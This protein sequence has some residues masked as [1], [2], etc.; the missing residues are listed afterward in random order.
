MCDVATL[1]LDPSDWSLK[2]SHWNADA[3]QRDEPPEWQPTDA[4]A[5]AIR[6]EAS[7]TRWPTQ[8][9]FSA[10]EL[11]PR[12]KRKPIP[13]HEGPETHIFCFFNEKG[14]G[15]AI[16]ERRDHDDGERSF[17]RW[18]KWS[19]GEWR[20]ME[21]EGLMPLFGIEDVPGSGEITAIIHEGAK[22]A[23][24]WRRLVRLA[25]KGDRAAV[26]YL[27]AHP[28]GCALGS[29]LHLGWSGG[30]FAARNTD[31]AA[32]A[33]VNIK[34]VHIIADNDVPGHKA[35][36]TI[37]SLLKPHPIKVFAL[38]FDS[39][40][41]EGFDLG[42]EMP[43]SLFEDRNGSR[44]YIGPSY[45]ELLT[46]ATWTTR[47]FDP[48]PT[49]KRG[50]P[51]SPIFSL[52][53]EFTK[54]WFVIP[55]NDGARFVH[56]DRRTH[57]LD[58][59]GLNVLVAPFTDTGANVAKLLIQDDTR[60]VDG[61]AYRPGAESI[62]TEDGKRLLN[63]WTAP[64]LQPRS[65][66]ARK[67]Q[68]ACPKAADWEPEW[69]PW[70]DYLKHLLPVTEDRE[71]VSRWLA[72][73]IARPRVRMKF[74]ILLFSRQQGTG[75]ST[76]HEVLRR[77]LGSDNV[78]NPNAH[79][80]TKSQFNGFIAHK[81]LI[82]VNEIY[83]EGSWAAYRALKEQ[84]TDRVIYVN[85]KHEK[86][87]TLENWSHYILCSNAPVGLSIENDDRRWLVPE[88]TEERGERRFWDDFYGW[89]DGDGP[90][91]IA[92]WAE[93]F[94]EKHGTFGPGDF[95]PSTSRKTD[96][97]ND[98]RGEDHRLIA[99]LAD[100]AI[101]RAKDTGHDVLLVDEEVRVWLKVM[102]GG[103]DVTLTLAN[104]RRALVDGGMHEGKT[105]LRFGLNCASPLSDKAT[106]DGAH[107]KQALKRR[108]CVVD[109]RN[110]TIGERDGERLRV[111]P[112]DLI[113]PHP[114]M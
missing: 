16:E 9:Y 40:F 38:R 39:R 66:A 23:A 2:A 8:V 26:D 94:A 80:L 44:I 31:W 37:S 27:A 81:R 87:Y 86:A 21:P 78:S 62:F 88:V 92:Q 19:D 77:V 60:R 51:P 56:E 33:R 70:T 61:L 5:A 101:Q 103:R 75:K 93:A 48:P 109:Q 52:R 69:Q 65:E 58:E 15:V 71:H 64:I 79:M 3:R 7:K 11:P 85:E 10:G 17:H 114:I 46:P 54:E 18:T 110:V 76:L 99:D 13:D 32:L 112:N 106:T 43:G 1:R 84:I 111:S 59:H 96:L 41:P 73:L 108:F 42:D 89:L 102:R 35:I 30:A 98:S 113:P 74:G 6:E 72:T 34:C 97:I 67:K 12:L 100:A 47:R 45:R 36:R 4:E 57:R 29:G 90:F 28:W 83:S 55:E 50:R 104:I 105:R 95:A 24:R 49:G 14:Q 25:K 53:P 68:A 82:F 107:A 22:A 63:T 91:L 20:A